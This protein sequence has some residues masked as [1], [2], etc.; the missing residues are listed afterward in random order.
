MAFPLDRKATTAEMGAFT[1]AGG[2]FYIAVTTAGGTIPE[3]RPSALSEAE[4][5]AVD[6]K[7]VGNGGSLPESGTQS[8]IVN[9]DTLGTTVTQKAKGVSDAGSGTLEVAR[10]ATDGGQIA[11]R[12]AAAT[13]FY[14][15]FKVQLTD[16]PSSDYTN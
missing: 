3:A 13:K 1:N 10:N 7:E 16:A 6:W 14:Y 9:Y 11:L 8:N 15:A 5:E 12:A 2:K 4:Y